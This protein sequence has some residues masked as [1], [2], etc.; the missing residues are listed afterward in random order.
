MVNLPDSGW[1]LLTSDAISRAAEVDEGFLGSWDVPLAV[2][3]GARLLKLARA[4]D[5]LVIY[6]HSPQQWPD[7]RK[8]PA[9]FT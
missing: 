9:W 3:H 8:A 5:A 2:H 4:R 7:L 1:I 6:G